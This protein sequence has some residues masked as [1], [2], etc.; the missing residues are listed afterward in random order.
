LTEIHTFPPAYAAP[1]SQSVSPSDFQVE[2]MPR[3]LAMNAAGTEG[4]S[5]G[6][7]LTPSSS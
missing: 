4:I 6:M 7:T 5:S 3:S 1:V 2:I